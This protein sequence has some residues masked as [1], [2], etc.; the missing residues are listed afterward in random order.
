MKKIT[1]FLSLLYFS[2]GFSQNAPITFETGQAG[3]TWTLTTF[4]NGTNPAPTVV[5]N[6][7]VGGLNTSALVCRFS[8]QQAGQPFA[9]FE[10][11]GIGT[12][13]LTNANCTIKILV[14]KS[15]ISD[16][17]I[18]FA[19]ASGASTGELKVA[20]TLINQWEELTFDFSSKVGQP[21][22]TGITQIVFFP[23][24][25][26]RTTTNVCFIDNVRF[27]ALS[28]PVQAVP[29]VAAPTPT[30]PAANVLSLFSNAYTN[31]AMSTWQTSW[32]SA[33]L[34]DLQIAGNDTKRYTGLDFVGAESTGV[35]NAT[36]MTTLHVDIWT[37]NM[38]T[39]KIKLVNFGANGIFGGGDDSE[40]ELSYTPTQNGWNAYEIPLTNFTGLNGRQALAQFIMVGVP[41]GTSTMYM[42]NFYFHNVPVVDPNT[43]MTAAPTPTIPAAN[44]IS[45]FSNAYTNV[46][47]DTWR[48][49][50]SNATLADVQIVGNDTKKYTSLDFVGIETTNPRI[51]ATAMT[52]V[53]FDAW[54][55][56]M[57]SL[58]FKLVDFGANGAFAG[59]DDSE[60]EVTL[61]PTLS[62][63]NSYHLPLSSFTGLTNRANLVQYIFSGLPVGQ[64]TLFIDNVYFTTVA[65]STQNFERATTRVYPNP[66]NDVLTFENDKNIEKI[67]IFNLV[68]QQVFASN[69]AENMSTVNVSSL[70]KGVYMATFTV[71][72][73]QSTIK[74]IKN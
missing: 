2:V 35:V 31:A 23:D 38:T 63:W 59:G 9:G 64:S 57:T 39:F 24:F 1:Y 5:A 69:P 56:N 13:N 70:S 42:D 48:T 65:L 37:P 36:S 62:G 21:T 32:S 54:T 60:H 17:G 29:M 72:G 41:T 20:N 26:A 44:V 68:G 27:S 61:T 14:Y 28:A 7:A 11:S 47:V 40:S 33:T 16:V 45:M 19:T 30:R 71:D 34:T 25:Q 74:F 51:N 73:V 3:N 50:W 67:M 66:V 4:E 10:T 55:P 8:A 52:F 49:P 46:P 53:H 18:K 15:V 43:P 12:F 58:R 6:P 22:S